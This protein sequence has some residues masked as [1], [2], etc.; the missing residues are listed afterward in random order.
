MEI[1]KENLDSAESTVNAYYS[2]SK[3]CKETGLSSECAKEAALA[4]A[5][6]PASGCGGG[7]VSDCAKLVAINGA[8]GVCAAY[9]AGA[10]APVCAWAAAKIINYCW[11]A[12]VSCVNY[13][14]ASAS[15]IGTYLLDVT[16]L[17][18]APEFESAIY[19]PLMAKARAAHYAAVGEWV[20]AMVS[21]ISLTRDD[22]GM[23]K[24]QAEKEGG[25]RE[26]TITDVSGG[27]LGE[28]Y[29]GKSMT[30][31][32][33]V[34]RWF[35]Y[36]WNGDCQG[37]REVPYAQ[38][39]TDG[40]ESWFQYGACFGGADW[41]LN[42]LATDRS[43]KFSWARK[44]VQEGIALDSERAAMIMRNGVHVITQLELQNP[45]TKAALFRKKIADER[46][47]Y[48]AW[49]ESPAGRQRAAALKAELQEAAKFAADKAAADKA[50]V[51][52]AV[53]R[54]AA[55]KAAAKAD[56]A[57]LAQRKRLFVT[58]ALSA[59]TAGVV[60]AMVSGEQKR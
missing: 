30:L 24:A 51:A 2:A 42:K 29:K 38:R 9:T 56:A 7:N 50:A 27:F 16:G 23:F 11:P 37:R 33:A 45:A 17:K 57:N 28:E 25:K 18:D 53:A 8:A 21:A 35:L 52:K 34:H 59:I 12:V 22:I 1:S 54:G 4:L 32:M 60:F 41:R 44:V 55:A 26:Y 58:G 19:K 31:A 14:G 46:A 20:A 48:K 40:S 6:A 3:T 5:F 36:S 10:A 39:L 13:I 49:E 15:D 47:A 43:G